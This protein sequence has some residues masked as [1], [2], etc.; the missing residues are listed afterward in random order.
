MAL[1]SIGPFIHLILQLF[2][3]ASQY[4][5][6]GRYLQRSYIQ[7]WKGGVI[8]FRFRES[9]F[10]ESEKLYIYSV[11]EEIMTASG[12]IKF[13]RSNEYNDYLE[14]QRGSSCTSYVGR[15]GGQQ[16]LYVSA[17]CLGANGRERMLHTFMHSLG[18]QEEFRRPDRDK[19]IKIYMKNLKER[20]RKRFKKLKWYYFMD[21]LDTPYDLMSVM[22]PPSKYFSANGKDT[23]RLK[24]RKPLP[25]HK[26]LSRIDVQ[27]LR[28]ICYTFYK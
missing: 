14:I 12:C 21:Y 7:E 27:R 17:E 1:G 10:S 4:T 11:M 22:H 20:D 23:I 6:Y 19:Y 24:N 25:E 9:D 3:L 2:I 16:P 8:P 28:N 13:K 18:F 15:Q 26:G 5:V